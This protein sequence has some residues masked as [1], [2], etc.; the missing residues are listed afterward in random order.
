MERGVRGPEQF[1][2]QCGKVFSYTSPLRLW[3]TRSNHAFGLSKLRG[4][5]RYVSVSVRVFRSEDLVLSFLPLP[6][7]PMTSLNQSI[8]A[9]HSNLA[10]GCWKSVVVWKYCFLV[11]ENVLDTILLLSAIRDA[12][13]RPRCLLHLLLCASSCS[14]YFNVHV[15]LRRGCVLFLV[16]S[17]Y[18][19]IIF[20]FLRWY[21]PTEDGLDIV[22]LPDIHQEYVGLALFPWHSWD[23]LALCDTMVRL[24]RYQLFLKLRFLDEYSVHASNAASD[25]IHNS[26]LSE[27]VTRTFLPLEWLIVLCLEVQLSLESLLSF[28]M[29]ICFPDCSLGCG[30]LVKYA[31]GRPWLC[32][33]WFFLFVACAGSLLVNLLVPMNSCGDSSSMVIECNRA[34]FVVF[35]SKTGPMRTLQSTY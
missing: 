1:A 22:R 13:W 26:L 14:C 18:G 25:E 10:T 31:H 7:F 29:M 9:N 3:S 30:T 28:S 15:R 17:Q 34:K 27:K 16:R 33:F 8:V 6:S 5:F 20:P 19:P 2:E 21:L 23:G 11:D 12:W 4:C 32:V 35:I 24:R